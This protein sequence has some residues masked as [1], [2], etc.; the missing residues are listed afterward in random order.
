MKT[1][2]FI[3]VENTTRE[4]LI[5][6]V[7]ELFKEEVQALKSELQQRYPERSTHPSWEE[8]L[9]RQ[10]V[11]RMLKIDLSTLHLWCKEGKLKKYGIGKRVYFK[12]SEIEAAL[13]LI[14][15]QNR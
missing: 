8:L 10:E 12:R 7:R 6:E 9:S 4:D 11:A 15:P 3:R 2:S 13:V 5:T 14:N 1:S